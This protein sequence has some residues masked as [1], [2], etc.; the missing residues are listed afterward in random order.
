MSEVVNERPIP[1]PVLKP[2]DLKVGDVVKYVANVDKRFDTRYGSFGNENYNRWQ[3]IDLSKHVFVCRNCY[4]IRTA[5]RNDEYRI[6]EV[7]KL[8]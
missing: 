4:G 3:I 7:V 2:F 1:P 5:F 8:D 6:G